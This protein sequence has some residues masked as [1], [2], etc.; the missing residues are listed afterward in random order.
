M[1]PFVVNIREINVRACWPESETTKGSIANTGT[2][3]LTDDRRGTVKNSKTVTQCASTPTH[4]HAQPSP[5]WTNS[6]LTEA[7]E[8]NLWTFENNSANFQLHAVSWIPSS[9]TPKS[10]NLTKVS[11][12]LR[13]RVVER[14]PV[15]VANPKRKQCGLLVIFSFKMSFFSDPFHLRCYNYNSICASKSVISSSAGKCASC[16][17][18]NMSECARA[19]IAV[20]K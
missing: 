5:T 19:R 6:N 20:L 4:P 9:M 16:K 3:N 18:C 17:E 14:I 11:A 1:L 8:G 12:K 7:V 2:T 13:V 10:K 15:W